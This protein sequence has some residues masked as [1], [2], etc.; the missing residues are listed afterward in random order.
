MSLSSRSRLIPLLLSSLALV[1][2][3]AGGGHAGAVPELL[4]ASVPVQPLMLETGAEPAPVLGAPA[5]TAPYLL[6][7]REPGPASLSA[8][9]RGTKWRDGQALLQGYLAVNSIQDLSRTGG[10]SS[11]I[12]GGSGSINQ[13]PVI[14]GGGQFKLGGNRVDLGLEAMMSL[15]GRANGG[16]FVAGGGG[17]AVAVSLDLLIV[18]FYGG[19]F[20]SVPLGGR[21]RVYGAAGPV[22]QFANYHQSSAPGV[23]AGSGSGFGVGGYART[24]VELE[25]SPGSF[26]GVGARWYDTSVNLSSNFGDLDVEGVEAMLTF[27]TRH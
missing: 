12:E 26:I 10:T 9:R 6:G 7:L 27:S 11:D 8:Q 16:A 18:D 13:Y 19:P 25:I 5:P 3:R 23:E 2:C 20:I 14:G 21:A 4:E 24:G 22:V 15:G 1:S 17:A